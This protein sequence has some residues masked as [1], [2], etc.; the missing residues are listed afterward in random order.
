MHSNKYDNQAE[1]VGVNDIDKKYTSF[2]FVCVCA[3]CMNV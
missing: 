1:N 3:I 2:F